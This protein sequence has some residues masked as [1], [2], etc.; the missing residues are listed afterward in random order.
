MISGTIDHS[1]SQ[2][3][4]Y[5]VTVTATDP[6]GASASTQFTW[7]VTNPAPSA[8]DD[9]ATTAEDTAISGNVLSN[10]TDPDGDSLS[11]TQFT[12]NGTTYA[13]GDTASL[14]EGQL[15]LN[16]DGSWTFTPA[17]NWNGTVPAVSYTVSDGEG[18]TA[19]AQLDINVTPVNDGPV[20][21]SDEDMAV[22]EE[23][24]SGG[25]VDN[26][27][28][29]TDTTDSATATGT[30]VFSD[31]DSSNFMLSLTGPSA[32]ITSG[33]EALTWNWD[34]GSR[35]LTG[36]NSTGAVMTV[37]V[38]DPVASGNGQYQ[39]DYTVTL[40]QPLDHPVN[41]TEDVLNIP[42][43]YTVSDGQYSDSGSFTVSV[44]DDRPV[45]GPISND[46]TVPLA[47][48]NVMLILDFS[49]SMQGQ[50][51]ADMKAAVMSMLDAY[52]RAGYAVV[53]LV[54]FSTNASIP[55]DGGWISINDAKAFING[56]T[57]A[58]MGGTT[59]YDDALAKA[60]AAFA[61]TSG[62]IPGGKNVAYFLSD[63][64]PYPADKGIN[65]SEQADWEN[66][67]RANH[68][69][70]YAVGFGASNVNALEPIA[71][72]G[73]DDVDRPAIDAT[74]AGTNLTDSLLE[75]VTQVVPGNLFGSLTAGGFGADGAGAVQQLTIDGVTYTYDVASDTITGSNGN[76]FSGH[77][78]TVTTSHNGTLTVN[79]QTGEYLY[80]ADPAFTSAYSES[81]GYA[82][83]DRDGDATSG[84]LTLNVDRAAKPTAVLTADAD[85]VYESAL[86]TGTDPSSPAEVATG[87][88]F[89]NDTIPNGFVLKD[90]SIAGGTTVD[91]G[92]TV[93]VTTAEGNTLVVDK[94]TGDYTYT[95]VNP[96]NHDGLQLIN[97]TFD[98]GVDGWSNAQASSGKLL[99]DRD[100]TVSKEFD[101]GP[102]Y[103]GKTVTISF[104][105]NIVGGWEDS[106]SY[107]DYFHVYVNGT[108]YESQFSGQYSQNGVTGHS[109][110]FD[111][112]LDAN[113]RALVE[114]NVDSTANDEK[115][116]IDNF[117]IVD[118]SV[119]DIQVDH[120]T[121]T[122]VDPGQTAYTSNL[123]VTIHDDAPI[124]GTQSQQV[125][126]PQ[127]DTNLMIILDLSGSMTNNNQNVDRLAAARAAINDLIDAYDGYGDVA[128][129]LVTFSTTA[130]EQTTYWMSAAE[131]KTVLDSL[132]AG[133]WTNYDAALAQA[134]QSWDD[135]SR[136]TTPP[137]GGTLNNVAYFI[138]DGQ[139][140]ANDGDPNVLA[141]AYAGTDT[142]DAGVQSAEEAAWKA[143]LEQNGIRAYA[144]G[145]GDGLSAQDQQ[146]LD[147]VA[148]DGVNGT[149][150]DAVMV[151]D[152]NDLSAVLQATAVSAVS[153]NLL[154]GA[155]P[156][157][158]GADGGYVST[159]VMDGTTYSW[160][161]QSAT[162]STTGNT[163]SYSF[164]SAT[165]VLSITT[166]AGGT[167]SVDLDDGNYNYYPPSTGAGTYVESFDFT[168][169]DRDGDSASGN[170]ALTVNF[171][172]HGLPSVTGDGGQNTLAGTANAEIL[173]ALGGDDV[174]SGQGG[175]DRL[176]GGDGQDQLDGGT[177]ND[178]LVGGDG[179]DILLGGAGDDLLVGGLGDDILTGG[180]GQDTFYWQQ[181]DAGGT[182]TITDFIAGQNGDVLDLKD[183]LVGEN[184]SNL[185]QYLSISSDGTDT[186]IVIDTDGSGNAGSQATIVLEGVDLTQ[187]GMLNEQQIIQ[188][189]LA[190]GNLEV[191]Q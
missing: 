89:A 159:L 28:D 65:A 150:L 128:V 157:Q 181:G 185:D 183:L 22:S 80:V 100:T 47:K 122:V 95:L 138:S 144:L 36:S 190:D 180:S 109:Y 67:L 166:S 73:I 11:V 136:I 61:E 23:G 124:A 119:T 90:V 121:Y 110:S 33:G 130:E 135:G 106:G 88:L 148:Y 160:D 93:T 151:P 156:G 143:F 175:S 32:Q 79:M 168:L 1:A 50:N 182:D 15:T 19:T 107:H 83:V 117:K 29:P 41:S 116:E 154:T 5:T 70:S 102:S 127:Q 105:M 87:S 24:L 9:S 164:D 101:F 134:M 114:L 113:G 71:Y 171:N 45:S 123:D 146:Y 3:G 74:A 27:G 40:H 99:I 140:N 189:L 104:D 10:D 68:I 54:T 173:S 35:T 82:L 13:A 120:F 155:T 92:T 172:E 63:G 46:L 55:N 60:Q 81:I 91:N 58:D 147:P 137:A 44:E 69:D 7:N 108:E 129:R 115:A 142:S 26:T 145:I 170:V 163:S 64:E 30:L 141:N 131:A 49:G 18:G 96:V 72:N 174:L 179:D 153:G 139:P 75:T 31:P 14:A 6:A 85:D 149:D 38:A 188:Q 53:Q 43:G 177:G 20:V 187:G 2:S 169:M 4:P 17:A 42:F 178:L 133:G 51:L 66:F 86:P 184:A 162:V 59:N 25:I 125:D 84:T 126:V 111:V 152:V 176:Y 103:A 78:L 112:Q 56:L 48:A 191:D 98:T 165:H 57:D 34:A 94:A 77:E 118:P 186:T 16:S 76:T 161:G 97:E 8:A 158:I 132:T 12:V 167:L 37:T 52:D 39:V 21:L 62:Y